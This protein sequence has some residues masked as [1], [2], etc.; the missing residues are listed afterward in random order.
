MSNILLC[1]S[2]LDILLDCNLESLF[3]FQFV[4][5]YGSSLQSAFHCLSAKY[6]IESASLLRDGTASAEGAFGF[7]SK[8]KTLEQGSVSE[9]NCKTKEGNKK[10]QLAKIF[11]QCYSAMRAKFSKNCAI[12]IIITCNLYQG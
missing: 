9:A 1:T 11:D 5:F 8:I 10:G 12:K 7:Q 4:S 2:Y 3:P 6:R